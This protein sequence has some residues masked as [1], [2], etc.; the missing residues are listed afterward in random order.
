VSYIN[1]VEGI[2]SSQLPS[3][4]P[5]VVVGSLWEREGTEEG[6][7]SRVRV[8][9]PKGDVVSVVEAKSGRF[10]E[11]RRM[12][13]NISIGGFTVSST[14]IYEVVVEQQSGDDWIEEARLPLSITQ[15]D[16]EQMRQLLKKRA[17]A[18]ST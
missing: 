2:T 1:A 10:G 18:A 5:P 9:S 13:S 4:S 6:L 17:A 15:M 7:A 8:L 3:P 14:G 16:P 12:R 11:A